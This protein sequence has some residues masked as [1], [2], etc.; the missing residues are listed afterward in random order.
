VNE[1]YC[2]G[3]TEALTTGSGTP[4]VALVPLSTTDVA[5]SACNAVERAFPLEPAVH[6]EACVDIAY[7]TN[8]PSSGTHYGIWPAYKEYGSAIP[9]GFLVHGMEHGAVV[10]GY[11]CADCEDEVAEARALLTELG[12]DPLCCTDPSCAGAS[13]RVVLAPDPRL[14]TRWAASSWGFTL[15]ADCFEA[16]AFRGFVETHRGR[17]PEAVCSG[18]VD[19]AS[20]L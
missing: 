19:V 1:S 16:D 12:A 9:R 6:T 5:G 17:G 13:T 8:P 18:G 20:S 15:V 11:S 4:A 3:A 14:S 7:G 10:I 2:G